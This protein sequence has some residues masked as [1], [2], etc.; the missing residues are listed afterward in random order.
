[1]QKL[2]SHQE[3]ISYSDFFQEIWR[4]GMGNNNKLNQQMWLRQL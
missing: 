1:M 2:P 3:W 4:E